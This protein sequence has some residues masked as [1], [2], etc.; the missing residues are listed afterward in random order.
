MSK[1]KKQ[2]LMN[3]RT[4]K[5]I[6]SEAYRCYSDFWQGFNKMPPSCLEHF[7]QNVKTEKEIRKDEEAYKDFFDS[8]DNTPDWYSEDEVRSLLEEMREELDELT[9]EVIGYIE[10]YEPTK[11]DYYVEDY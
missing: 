9:D 3:V 2:G 8:L 11:D 7:E 1:T 4:I 10:E 6:Q 5:Q